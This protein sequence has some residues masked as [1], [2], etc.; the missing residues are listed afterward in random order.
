M[1]KADTVGICL[2][3]DWLL[4]NNPDQCTLGTPVEMPNLGSF[5][6]SFQYPEVKLTDTC[7]SYSEKVR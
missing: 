5:G 6:T 7:D 3:C 1:N 4:R 2:D